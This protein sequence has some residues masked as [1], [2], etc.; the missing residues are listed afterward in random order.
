[1]A[2]TLKEIAEQAGVSQMTVSR[3]LNGKAAGQVSPEVLQRVNEVVN[4]CGYLPRA[5]RRDRI[6]PP[7]VNEPRSRTVTMLIPH[8]DF[9]NNPPYQF[10][11][12]RFNGATRA[13]A[14]F[15]GRLETLPIS[16]NNT[17][18]SIAWE[19]LEHLGQ[20]D[21]ILGSLWTIIPLVELERRGCKIA[22]VAKDVFWRD[23]YAPQLKNWAVFTAN[24]RGAMMK[25]VNHLS[26][27]GCKKIAMMTPGEFINEPNNPYK[28]GYE[29]GMSLAGLDYRHII[30]MDD[31]PEAAPEIVSKAFHDKPFDALIYRQMH[32]M[33]FDFTR[34]IQANIG[35]PDDVEVVSFTD[36][37]EFSFF[38]PKL[39]YLSHPD[40]Q[41]AYDA[42]KLLLS[43]DYQ[44]GER[45]YECEIV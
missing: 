14:E 23:I 8:P 24:S 6:S 45:F 18:D 3:I 11:A 40:E 16:K 39:K 9:L 30:L 37:K 20:G 26:S 42:V 10:S 44:P 17:M 38:R 29:Q 19:W 33:D 28:I 12:K 22:A 13:A 32:L 31:N 43:N 21:L 5:T 15:G 35:V 2:T 7:V 4:R 36:D 34:T 41:I 1:M 25:L 27:A